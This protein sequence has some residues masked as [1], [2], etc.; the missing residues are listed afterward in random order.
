[1]CHGILN[2]DHLQLFLECFSEASEDYHAVNN[3]NTSEE[4]DKSFGSLSAFPHADFHRPCKTLVVSLA[5]PG[6]AERKEEKVGD[7]FQSGAGE[8]MED[9]DSSGWIGEDLVL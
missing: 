3:T 9:W 5:H 2:I 6:K 7:N 4:A 1:M 8:E